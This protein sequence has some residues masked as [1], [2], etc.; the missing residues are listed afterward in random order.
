MDLQTDLV[1]AAEA[2]RIIADRHG[3]KRPLSPRIIYAHPGLT[4]ARDHPRLYRRE[5]VERLAG[6][7]Q[8]VGRS[9]VLR[10][11][12]GK[13]FCTDKGQKGAESADSGATPA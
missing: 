2:G 7:Y 6:E 1:T 13:N 10:W 5:D 3:A 4:A 11:V 9:G 8:P 12:H